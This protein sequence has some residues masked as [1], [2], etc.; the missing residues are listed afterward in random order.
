MQGNLA[1]KNRKTLI[2]F[3]LMGTMF[4]AIIYRILLQFLTLSVVGIDGAHTFARIPF[5]FAFWIITMLTIRISG[6]HYN[7][8]ISLA[9]LLK[10][11]QENGF[12]KQLGIFYIIAQVIG[13]LLGAFIAL[14]LTLNGGNLSV[15]F[16]GS[17]AYQACCLEVLGSFLMCLIFIILNEK[18]DN[19]RDPALMSLFWSI[20]FVSCL[21][22]TAEVTGGSLNPAIGFAINLTMLANGQAGAMNW[23]WIYTIFPFVGSI[24]SVVFY[25]FVYQKTK[26]N[27]DEIDED[28]D[29]GSVTDKDAPLLDE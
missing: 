20:G 2:F 17:Y 1:E 18:Q 8:A 7:P 5:F 21:T 14:F 26:I 27:D 22:M 3:E 24:L 6:A 16:G 23:V 4:M 29:E 15:R 25:H 19:N 11:D 13:A 9:L 10:R 28:F 12:P